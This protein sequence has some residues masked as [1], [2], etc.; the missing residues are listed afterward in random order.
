M[1]NCQLLAAMTPAT[2]DLIGCENAVVEST[3]PMWAAK[4]NN[5]DG[6]VADV[7]RRVLAEV[8]QQASVDSLRLRAVARSRSCRVRC[9]QPFQDTVGP[10]TMAPPGS[11]NER[12][13][14]GA[15]WTGT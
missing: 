10:G 6:V 8:A 9:R 4:N 2:P 14:T 3:K 11:G 7:R 15:R 5:E 1:L 12:A 13:C